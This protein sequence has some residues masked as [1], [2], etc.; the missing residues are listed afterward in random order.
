MRYHQ[1]RKCTI[2]K[3]SR[4]A[5]PRIDG[6]P[7]SV[8]DRCRVSLHASHAANAQS[9]ASPDFRRVVETLTLKL[10][11]SGFHRAVVVVID[12]LISPRKG[13]LALWTALRRK[14]ET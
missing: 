6:A 12:N 4:V 11:R 9:H 8:A 7:L 3:R 1:G 5:L 13:T 2:I 14:P 10:A